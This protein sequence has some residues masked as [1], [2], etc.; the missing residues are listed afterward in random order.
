MFSV[1]VASVVRW[2]QRKRLTGGVKAKPMGG[3]VKPK[4]GPQ[5][6]WRPDLTQ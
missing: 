5:R 4:L 1:G 2:C 3:K 6:E